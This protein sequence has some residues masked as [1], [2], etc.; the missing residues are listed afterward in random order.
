MNN[1]R[2]IINLLEDIE[3]QDW[4]HGSSVRFDSFSLDHTGV[5]NDQAGYGFYF[6]NDKNEAMRYA[7]K[8]V[9]TVKLGLTDQID[10]MMHG[11]PNSKILMALIQNTPDEYASSNW[12]DDPRTA[13]Q[14]GL[15][16]AMSCDTMYEALFE[17]QSSWYPTQSKQ[18]LQNAV[19]LGLVGFTIGNSETLHAVMYN[20]NAIDIIK[21]EEV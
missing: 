7:K 12:D 21:V 4:Y 2:S 10:A 14:M 6:T 15:E 18:F 11:E 8:C 5:G 9:Y 13:Y 17:I 1:F 20:P 16:A 19:K 3:G